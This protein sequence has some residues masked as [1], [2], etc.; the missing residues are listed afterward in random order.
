MPVLDGNVRETCEFELFT[1]LSGK[2]VG[3][4]VTFLHSRSLVESNRPKQGFP[5]WMY[6]ECL[7]EA[8]FI[9]IV[10]ISD[11]AP[12]EIVATDSFRVQSDH[13]PWG[14][15]IFPRTSRV[16]GMLGGTRKT[17]GGYHM[18]K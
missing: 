6:I 1:Q 8:F 15:P 18:L 16:S 14:L 5:F 10:P 7:T 12:C 3:P 13:G 9:K 11:V 17:A 2:Y 4:Q